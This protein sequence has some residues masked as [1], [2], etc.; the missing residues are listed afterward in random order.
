MLP[1]HTLAQET[2]GPR[3]LTRTDKEIRCDRLDSSVHVISVFSA[4]ETVCLRQLGDIAS[5]RVDPASVCL[6][7]TAL[8][9]AESFAR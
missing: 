2:T 6:Q 4:D 9:D 7:V 8:R 1:D 3:P 5:R